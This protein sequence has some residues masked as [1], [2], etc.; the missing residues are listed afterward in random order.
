MGMRARAEAV[1]ASLIEILGR[2]EVFEQR[3]AAWRLE[4]AAVLES[5]P[6][7]E[8]EALLSELQGLIEEN[9]SLFEQESEA[10]VRSLVGER[11]EHHKARSARARRY[12]DVGKMGSGGGE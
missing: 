7:E 3:F 5:L 1:K 4:C 2:P 11:K 8:R 12:S 10:L 6:A 9:R